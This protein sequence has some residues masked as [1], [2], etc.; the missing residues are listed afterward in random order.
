MSR[1][2]PS[3]T[4]EGSGSLLDPKLKVS[5]DEEEDEENIEDSINAQKTEESQN[6]LKEF[7]MMKTAMKKKKTTTTV[8]QIVDAKRRKN[9]HENAD[10]RT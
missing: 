6:W 2:H 7:E 5:H 3:L 1:D 8:K 9:F 4:F 10:V